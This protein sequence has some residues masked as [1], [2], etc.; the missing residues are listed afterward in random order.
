ME[1]PIGSQLQPKIE[2][3]EQNERDY[4]QRLLYICKGNIEMASR[5]SGWS[6]TTIYR[7]IS[8]YGVQRTN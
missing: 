3:A 4:L 1:L 6:R 8:F 7:K 5:V 2:S